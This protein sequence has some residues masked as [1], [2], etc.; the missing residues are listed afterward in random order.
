MK[1]TSTDVIGFTLLVAIVALGAMAM[2]PSTST[3]DRAIELC[4]KTGGT[5]RVVEYNEAAG[6]TLNCLY[7]DTPAEFMENL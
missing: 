2:E 3:S 6:L 4:E 5:I 7:A 1:I